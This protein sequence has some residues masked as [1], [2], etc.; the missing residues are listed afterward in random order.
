[1]ALRPR[2]ATRAALLA[3]MQQPLLVLWARPTVVRL[4]SRRQLGAV[5][6]AIFETENLA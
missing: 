5:T 1:M 6:K 3:R 2:Q 4:R